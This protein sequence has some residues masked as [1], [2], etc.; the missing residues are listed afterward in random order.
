MAIQQLLY[1]MREAGHFAKIQRC[2][3]WKIFRGATPRD[4]VVLPCNVSL[5]LGLDFDLLG[6]LDVR[7][8]RRGLGVGHE[9]GIPKFRPAQH[10]ASKHLL[11]KACAYIRRAQA[12]L[13]TCNSVALAAEL[14]PALIPY[15]AEF[16][17]LV[18]ETQVRVVLAKHQAIF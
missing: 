6:H 9:P 14:S 8:P 7:Y 12:F 5:V 4:L 10:L 1:F 16:S 17:T 18:R 11:L 3:Q 13:F 15:Q 2:R